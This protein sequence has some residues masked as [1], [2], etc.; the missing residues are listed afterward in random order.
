MSQPIDLRPFQ[1]QRGAVSEL[2]ELQHRLRLIARMLDGN[3][4]QQ[5]RLHAELAPILRAT[6]AKIDELTALA[7]ECL[8]AAGRVDELARRKRLMESLQDRPSEEEI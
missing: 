5:G 7:I 6:W 8:G 4:Q 3:R 1:A 2:A